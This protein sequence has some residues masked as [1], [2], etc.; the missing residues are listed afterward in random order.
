[1]AADLRV[2]HHQAAPAEVDWGRASRQKLLQLIRR[3]E[4]RSLRHVQEAEPW[5]LGN[6]KISCQD[7]SD[8]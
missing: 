8:Q 1:M 7:G 2:V 6:N 5:K 4:A 3:L